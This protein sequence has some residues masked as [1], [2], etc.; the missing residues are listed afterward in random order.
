[1]TEEKTYK[2]RRDFG[3]KVLIYPAE[4]EFEVRLMRLGLRYGKRI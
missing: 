2:I 1:M 3:N 4:I